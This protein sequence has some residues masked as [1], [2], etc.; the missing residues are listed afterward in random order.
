VKE[1]AGHYHLYATPLHHVSFSG[2]LKKRE[3][4]FREAL[5]IYTGKFEEILR[6]YPFQW[7]NYY[8]FWKLPETPSFIPDSN[9]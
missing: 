2:N 5:G 3:E 7:F 1:S 6:K 4:N 8:D 9:I